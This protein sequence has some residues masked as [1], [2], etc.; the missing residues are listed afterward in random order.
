MSAYYENGTFVDI[1]KIEGGQRYKAYMLGAHENST[2]RRG[3]GKPTQYCPLPSYVC[4]RWP[5]KRADRPSNALVPMLRALVA[6]AET[7]LE[8]RIDFVMA[9]AINFQIINHAE[10]SQEVREYLAGLKVSSWDRLPHSVPYLVDAVTTLGNCS[11][12]YTLPEDPAFY[13]DPAQEI[14]FLEYTR[15]A[16]V[17]GFWEEECG[18]AS[19]EDGFVK[20][21][22]GQ[23]ALASC[24]SDAMRSAECDEHFKSAIR[25]LVK[26]KRK[27][28]RD[29][30]GLDAVLIT[31]ELANDQ[32]MRDLVRQVL[33]GCF[34]DGESINMSLVQAF[35]PDPA[36]ALSRA[37]ALGELRAKELKEEERQHD[38]KLEL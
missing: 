14:L 4:R 29:E 26:G 9:S 15:H 37:M 17:A 6:S 2:A 10:M 31:G 3:D 22:L 28:S 1:A 12:P 18:V 13:E 27:D 20:Q 21:D 30:P 24:R 34:P 8:H 36:F 38:L 16:L 23:S 11:D 19:M 35:A 32:V 5:F 25:T 33:R 7:T